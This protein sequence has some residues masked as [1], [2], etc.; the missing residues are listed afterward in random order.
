M[1]YINI[2]TVF[3]GFEYKKEMEKEFTGVKNARKYLLDSLQANLK[4]LVNRVNAD[5]NNKDLMLEYQ[6]QREFYLDKKSIFEEEEV[7]MVRQFDEKIIKQLNSYVKSY[8]RENNY[9]VIYGATA[10]GSIMYGDSTLDLSQPVI[11]YINK[12]YK[13]K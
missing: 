12:K 11:E 13:G 4:A 6:K 3:D 5:K 7:T 8:G 9:S 2:K 1:G 10:N